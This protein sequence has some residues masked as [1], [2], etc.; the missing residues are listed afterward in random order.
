M[1]VILFYGC[2]HRPFEA[3]TA[4]P[5]VNAHPLASA[6]CVRVNAVTTTTPSN[7]NA[8]TMATTAIDV[9]LLLSILSLFPY[10]LKQR[11]CE[12]LNARADCGKPFSHPASASCVGIVITASTITTPSNANAATMAIIAIVVVF[13]SSRDEATIL[14]LNRSKQRLN[15]LLKIGLTRIV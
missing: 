9:I 6:S 1:C 14:F 11:P 12:A 5:F 13:S 8:A 10:G 2:K 7:A 15:A 4:T 3:F